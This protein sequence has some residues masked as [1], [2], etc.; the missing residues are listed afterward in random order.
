MFYH[1]IYKLHIWGKDLS[2]TKYFIDFGTMKLKKYFFR[3]ISYYFFQLEGEK[4]KD[5]QSWM[6]KNKRN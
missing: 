6:N 3:D 4:T 2:K 1:H 5:S